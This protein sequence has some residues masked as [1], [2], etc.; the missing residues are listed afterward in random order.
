VQ[1]FRFILGTYVDMNAHCIFS[2]SDSVL[3]SRN[4]D[5][6]VGVGTQGTGCRE[7]NDQSNISTIA[8]VAMQRQAH[9][10]QNGIGSTLSY[11]VHCGGHVNQPGDRAHRYAMIHGNY[12]RS[13]SFAIQNAL[14]S[15]RFSDLAHGQ[16]HVETEIKDDGR[17]MVCKKDQDASFG[18]ADGK[19]PMIPK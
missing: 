2:D 17:A 19:A 9:V 12:D 6:M 1:H 5:L 10:S 8:S 7:V 14:Q 11:L 16:N 4:H 13:V 18:P 15:D 3:H